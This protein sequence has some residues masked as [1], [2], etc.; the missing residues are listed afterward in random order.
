MNAP[1]GITY[2]QITRLKP[3]GV[4]VWYSSDTRYPEQLAKHLNRN[5]IQVKPLTWLRC[6]NVYGRRFTDI[7]IDHHVFD[8]REVNL[9]EAMK[10][11]EYINSTLPLTQGGR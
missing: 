10:A 2:T 7:G 3:N 1:L 9:D 5:D 6:S 11:F 4:F 8:D